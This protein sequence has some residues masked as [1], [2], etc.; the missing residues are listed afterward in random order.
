VLFAAFLVEIVAYVV[1]RLVVTMPDE[2]ALWY[3]VFLGA[4]VYGFVTSLFFYLYVHGPVQ[5][6]QPER[7][8]QVPTIDVFITTYDEDVSIVRTTAQ[9]ALDMALPHRTWICDD[10][11]RP[12]MKAAAEA[13]GVGYLTRPDNR[14]YKAGNINNALSRTDGELVLILDADHVPRRQLL[15]STVGFLDDPEVALVQTPQVFYNLD[16]FQHMPADGVNWHEASLFHHRIQNG[17]DRF[18]MAFSV[19]TG[20]LIRRSALQAI[21]GVP[22]GSV[23]EDIHMSMG[24]HAA[25]YRTVYVDQPL[26]FLLAP[27]TPLAYHV[28]R[29]RWAQGSL[30][31]L[32]R[33]NPLL[34]RGLGAFQ[35]LAYLNSLVWPLAYLSYLVFFVSPFFYL[36]LGISPMFA[37]PEVVVPVLAAHLLFQWGVL[38][39]LAAPH[40]QP[41]KAEIY[42]MIT[43]PTALRAL[44]RF[45]WPDGL[46]F[47]VTP[48]GRH[49]GAPWATSLFLV[50][51]LVFNALG[52]GAAGVRVG[53]GMGDPLGIAFAG[54]FCVLFVAVATAA[55]RQVAVKRDGHRHYAVPVSLTASA[56]KGASKRAATVFGLCCEV[57]DV[58]LE[59]PVAVGDAL[60]LNLSGIGLPKP[61]EAVVRSVGPA[62]NEARV[63][64][65]GVDQEAA[66]RLEHFLYQTALP[67]LLGEMVDVPPGPAPELVGVLSLSRRREERA[68]E[69]AGTKLPRRPEGVA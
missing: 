7:P 59:H 15:L 33:D 53:V 46:R 19:G 4:E 2:P 49:S 41:F 64:L 47:N 1:W 26:G 42:R 45:L 48:K 36:V 12:E 14:H 10:G 58:R 11:R 68:R 52:V 66:D 44:P 21:G 29:L 20:A 57:A 25:G 67:A 56:W 23:T 27:E 39:L 55:L 8:D 54:S 35:R 13:L 43:L 69:R 30:Q 32:R 18:G 28:Q 6:R 65:V 17:A 61:L 63:A 60:E 16:S 3:W 9:A 5:R 22:T 34:K 38:R 50:A 51:M 37:P 31:I 40:A 62:S 24:L